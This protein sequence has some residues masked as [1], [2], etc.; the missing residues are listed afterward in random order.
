MG[1]QMN[2][3]DAATAA[4]KFHIL[5]GDATSIST[6]GTI[7]L[8]AF[9]CADGEK[10]IVTMPSQG[11]AQMRQMISDLQD[12]AKARGVGHGNVAPILPRDFAVGNS[13]QMRGAVLVLLNRDAPDERVFALTDKS[14][15]EL[16][17]ALKQNV[18]DRMTPQERA[19]AIAGPS[20]LI[21]PR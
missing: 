13:D 19:R 9:T 10:L 12:T 18:L 1:D 20:K 6:D 5:Y 2:G 3:D 7:A 4:R 16:A 14:A 11:I 8:L 17:D 15:L 21:I